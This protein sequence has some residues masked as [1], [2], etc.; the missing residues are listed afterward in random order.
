MMV[1]EGKKLCAKKKMQ[2]K[3][4]KNLILWGS[5]VPCLRPPELMPDPKNQKVQ[6]NFKNQFLFF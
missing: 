6:K 5:K 2:Q 4:N 1:Y 3:G